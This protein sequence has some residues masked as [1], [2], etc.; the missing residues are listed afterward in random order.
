MAKKYKVELNS[1]DNLQDLLQEVYLLAEEQIIQT[2]NEISK[3]SNAVN[4]AELSPDEIAKLSKSIHDYM[5]IK[6]RAIAKKLEVSK[7]LNE[8]ISHNGNVNGALEGGKEM[9]FSLAD[10]KKA[11]ADAY[12]KS[13]E[14]ESEVKTISL[15]KK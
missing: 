3:V 6:D 11:V 12:E 4:W 14:K 1:N 5:N 15:K 8:V 10:M 13:V 9:A 2:E 7:L